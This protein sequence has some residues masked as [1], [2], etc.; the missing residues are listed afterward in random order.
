MAGLIRLYSMIAVHRLFMRP[1]W[2]RRRKKVKALSVRWAQILLPSPIGLASLMA[3]M[4]SRQSIWKIRTIA[5]L[6]TVPSFDSPQCC[7]PASPNLF[8]FLLL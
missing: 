1:A 3:G 8:R 7:S 4:W 6:N 5:T 2:T